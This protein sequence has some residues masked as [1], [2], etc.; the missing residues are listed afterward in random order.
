[1]AGL[2]IE[3][4]TGETSFAL[5]EHVRLLARGASGTTGYRWL[6]AGTVVA[7]GRTHAFEMDPDAVGEYTA[8][9]RAQDG[10]TLTGTITLDV[11]LPDSP[12]AGS[13]VPGSHSALRAAGS[14][15]AAPGPIFHRLFALVAALILVILGLVVAV[16]IGPWREHAG[17][18]DA[19]WAALDGRLKVAIVLGLP[20]MIFGSLVLLVGLW[21]A[22]V[23]WR[24]GLA[25]QPRGTRG[26][27]GDAA[28]TE[29][30]GDDVA[31]VVAAVG[32]LR[33]AAL[34]MVVGA[35]LMLGSAWV[36]ASAAGA[37]TNASPAA[38][39][40]RTPAPSPSPARSVAPGS[41]LP[42]LSP[43]PAAT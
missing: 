10:T 16:L 7:E 17:L 9:A 41:P 21:M 31:K 29:M 37:A 13:T 14:A 28:S 35:I 36:A 27:R 8:E 38:T 12:A 25:N 15:A 18:S 43:G 19:E 5:G 34:A 39:P 30:T 24:G 20:A 3:T 23:E 32:A 26:R 2:T 22:L 4:Q 6:R 42:S 33:G 11:S 40:V 1:L